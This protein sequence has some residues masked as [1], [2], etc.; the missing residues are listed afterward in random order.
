MCVFSTE[1]LE[2]EIAPGKKKRM[3]ERYDFERIVK[4]CVGFPRKKPT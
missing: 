3:K 2:L 1:N 4:K